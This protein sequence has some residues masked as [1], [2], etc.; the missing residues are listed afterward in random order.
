MKK[1]KR[2]AQHYLLFRREGETKVW[3]YEY[4]QNHELQARERQGW[5]ISNMGGV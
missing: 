3:I 4:L 5:K 2:K 1:R